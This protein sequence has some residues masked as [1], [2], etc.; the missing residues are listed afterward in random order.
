MAGETSRAAASAR[1]AVRTRSTP[2][3]AALAWLLPGLG[4]WYLGHRDRASIFFVTIVVTFWGGVALGGV[5]STMNV[6]DNGAWFAAQLCAGVQSV[7]ALMW[8]KTIPDRLEL[9]A[10]YPTVDIAVVYTG[11]A[12]LLNLLVIIDALARAE[13]VNA[14]DLSSPRPAGGGGP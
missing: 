7:G 8:S 1:R 6:Q 10:T 5:R 9:T 2:L 11:I 3:T 14:P 12:G 13:A 4:H